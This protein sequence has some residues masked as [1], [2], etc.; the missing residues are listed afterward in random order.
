MFIG[1]N[2]DH[3]KNFPIDHRRRRI[4][5]RRAPTHYSNI[6]TFHH[7]NCERSELSSNKPFSVT[8]CLCVLVAIF[9]GAQINIRV[10]RPHILEVRSNVYTT[11][12]NAYPERPNA[13][14][15]RQIPVR[16]TQ[17]RKQHVG[18]LLR[19][20]IFLLST[21]DSYQE[22]QI[23]VRN[24]QAPKQRVRFLLRTQ[25]FLL[26]TPDSYQERQ[27]PVKNIDVLNRNVRILSST[28]ACPARPGVCTVRPNIC[29]VSKK[30]KKQKQNKKMEVL[31]EL[32]K[33][34]NVG[35][36]TKFQTRF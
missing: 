6:P 24:T 20:Q 13:C 31:Y 27:V 7:S 9:M 2:Q 14:S 12:P 28:D 1:N 25:I 36:F 29:V 8:F 23:P 17:M 4:S 10:V 30:S 33:Q 11:L 21:S 35:S 18:F 5:A 19:T 22:R 26:S 32:F 15:A 16:N 3:F 34:I